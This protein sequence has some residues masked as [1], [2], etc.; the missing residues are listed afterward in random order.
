M[1]AAPLIF[2]DQFLQIGSVLSSDFIYGIGEHRNKFLLDT[3]WTKFV[4]WSRDQP[5]TVSTIS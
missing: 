2:A 4:M 1:N 3:K 5:P